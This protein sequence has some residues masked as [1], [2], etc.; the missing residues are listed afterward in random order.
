MQYV[1]YKRAL[2]KCD[3]RGQKDDLASTLEACDILVGLRLRG[4]AKFTGAKLTPVPQRMVT[5]AAFEWWAS[6]GFS[7]DSCADLICRFTGLGF[8][9]LLS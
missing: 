4:L 1:Q 9:L 5:P 7:E 2:A 3:S 8:A 6:T